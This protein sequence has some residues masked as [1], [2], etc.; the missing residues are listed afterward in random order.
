M[1]LSIIVP[2]FNE[3][4][5]IRPFLES[6]EEVL[7]DIADVTDYEVI[8]CVDPCSDNTEDEIRKQRQHFPFVKLISLSRRFGQP[9]ATLAGLDMSTGRC[10]VVMDVD[11]QD[12]PSLIPKLIAQW[13]NGFDVVLARRLNRDGETFVKKKVSALGYAVINRL[14]EVPI[15][16]NTGDFRLLDRRVIE[17]LKLFRES[18]GFLRGLTALVGFKQ[19]FVEYDRPARLH[20][21]GKYN[22]YLGS[23]KIGLNGVFGFSSALLGLS[24]WLGFT[25][26]SSSFVTAIAYVIL[27][28]LGV[29]FPIGNPTIV[30]LVLL[31]GGLQLICFGIA[32]Q[33]I[34]RIYEEVKRRPRYI[35]ESM[36]GFN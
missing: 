19:T 29:P 26:A 14:S 17:H 4:D 18:H 3:R 34:G 30:V 10:A 35:I 15:P 36:E 20:G 28:V 5:N 16:Q 32:G 2:V 7:A 27:K 11:F 23:L 8:F 12:P 25:A 9:V 33:Y 22:R 31:L 24:T 21:A 13:K 6:I 1:D